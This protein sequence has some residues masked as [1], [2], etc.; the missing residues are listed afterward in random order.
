MR[1]KLIDPDDELNDPDLSERLTVLV[2]S[3]CEVMSELF[4]SEELDSVI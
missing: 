1:V 3:T 4:P 2:A